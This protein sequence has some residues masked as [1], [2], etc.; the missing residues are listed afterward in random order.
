M[1]R[2]VALLT[3]ITLGL[4]TSHAGAQGLPAARPEQVGL[5]SERLERVSRVL[6]AEI[7]AGKIPGAVALV[8][9]R[10]QIV[11]FEA[12]G[13][14]DKAAN[15]PMT[16]DAIFRLYSMTK[17]FTSVAAMML[18]E[19]GKLV[20]TDPVSKFIPQLGRREVSVPQFDPATGK[21]GYVTV[22]AEREIT[23]QDLLRHTSG[24][25]YGQNTPNTRVSELYEANKVG[26]ADQTPEEQI[27][28]L[29]RVPLASQ[30][31]TTW[32]YSL[33]TD[34]LGRVVEKVSGMRL[35]QF[36]AER[37]FAP[38]KM[39][40]T[41]FV[42]PA[43][44]RG[45]LAQPLTVEPSTGKPITLV[46]VTVT[47]KNDAGGAGSAGTTIDY[48]RFTQM[49]LN[50]GQLDGVRLLSPTTVAFMTSDHLGPATRIVSRGGVGV[51]YGF[52]LGFAVRT[53]A[54][55]AG[56]SGPV[57]E[58][59]WGGAAG[60]GFWID[61]PE[62]MVTVL[63]TQGAPGPARGALSALFRQMVRQAIVE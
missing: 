24:I 13:A 40:D 56:V 51:G 27:E 29:S 16:K 63:M 61:P 52:G 9:R 32:E 38:L 23:V 7:D 53:S 57:G 4:L 36:F 5:S 17:P 34:V 45:R 28:R 60:T 55:I 35:G 20:I 11:Y 25:V 1:K 33:S 30:P 39:T 14:R 19:D 37:I 47:P 42:V 50:G 62:Q 15:A 58:Y 12:F 31:G 59:R 43:D 48:A 22:P 21:V 44:K 10:G 3:L 49:M 2:H 6:R 54:G 8:A 46:D 26:W 18:M 41:A